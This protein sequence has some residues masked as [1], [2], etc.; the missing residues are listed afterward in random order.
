[1]RFDGLLAFA[2][3]LWLQHPRWAPLI[4]LLIRIGLTT[5]DSFGAFMLKLLQ[6][7]LRAHMSSPLYPYIVKVLSCAT[8]V[9]AELRVSGYTIVRPK[10]QQ[11]LDMCSALEMVN[12]SMMGRRVKYEDIAGDLSRL[13]WTELTTRST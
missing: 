2:N 3:E 10:G 5:D 6:D 13:V 9:A 12:A 1:M 8:I 7:R 11:L 4:E